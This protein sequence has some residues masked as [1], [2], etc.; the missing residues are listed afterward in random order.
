MMSG[1]NTVHH[2]YN[3]NTNLIHKKNELS[4]MIRHD[5]LSVPKYPYVVAYRLS[6]V[7]RTTL[8]KQS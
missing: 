2:G 6:N 1:Y 5:A 4:N 7:F 3:R 8:A